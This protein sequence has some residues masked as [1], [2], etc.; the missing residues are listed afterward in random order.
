MDMFRHLIIVLLCLLQKNN[1]VN[2]L[3]I[4]IYIYTVEFGF[5]DIP[6]SF[7]NMSIYPYIVMYHI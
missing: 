2:G 6:I 3:A 7:E 1:T 4:Y 5:I